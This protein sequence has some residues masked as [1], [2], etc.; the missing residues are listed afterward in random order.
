MY[1]DSLSSSFATHIE[2]TPTTSKIL[3]LMKDMFSSYCRLVRKHSTS[4]Y[5][6]I[7]QQAILVI[8]SEISEDLSLSKLAKLQN[9]S[10]GYL[11][12]LFKKETGKT[13]TQ[14]VKEKRMNYASD[15][16][17]TTHLQIQTIAS[18]CGIMDVQYFSKTFKAIKGMTPKEYREF[19]NNKK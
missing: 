17:A 16:L 14:F 13:V 5:S 9:I 1:L 10:S 6:P 3:L 2:Q 19:H 4:K 8:E 11:A 18:H 12:T 15:L 7:V